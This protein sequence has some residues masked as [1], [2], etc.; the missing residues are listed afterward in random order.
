VRGILELP[1]ALKSAI[2]YGRVLPQDRA[3]L[4][5]VSTDYLRLTCD[6][7]R[8]AAWLELECLALARG[9]KDRGDRQRAWR[10][11]GGYEDGW[12][13]GPIAYAEGRNSVLVQASGVASDPL[14]LACKEKLLDVRPTRFDVQATVQLAKDDPAY[15]RRMAR[16]ADRFRH[17]GKREGYPFKVHVRDGKGDGDTLEIGTRGSEVYLRLYDKHREGFKKTHSKQVQPG[18]F[19]PG[20]WRYEAELKGSAACE[21][22]SRLSEAPGHSEAVLS[23]V[24]GLFM[25]HGLKLPVGKDAAPPIRELRYRSDID[26]TRAWL[27]S[28]VRPSIEQLI[29]DGYLGEVIADLGLGDLVCVDVSQL[30]LTRPVEE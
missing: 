18:Q 6:D 4:G 29:A 8:A 12:S 25:D 10:Y 5:P 16:R 28:A 17:S 15:A 24:R 27:R 20:A 3:D 1:N 30:L 7:S 23:E 11:V 21:L 14:F 13:C 9:F 22:Y 2:P 19:A 26:R